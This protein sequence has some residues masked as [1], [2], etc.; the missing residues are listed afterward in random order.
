LALIAGPTVP[1]SAQIGRYPLP[2]RPFADSGACPFEGCVYRDWVASKPVTVRAA[3]DSKAPVAFDLAR[4]E[5]VRAVTG[6]VVTVVPGRIRFARTTTIHFDRD[7]IWSIL[8]S[9]TL[10]LL[11]YQGEGFSKVWFRGQLYT[12]VDI[13]GWQPADCRPDLARCGLTMLEP[14]STEWWARV[15]NAK[16]QFGWALVSGNFEGTDALGGVPTGER[17]SWERT[18]EE[19]RKLPTEPAPTKPEATGRLPFLTTS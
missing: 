18:P 17:T 8:P 14:P 5:R 7:S 2:P 13:S 15:R 4:G 10:Y 11:T 1:V 19:G 3:R 9:D 6:V 16:G 12:D